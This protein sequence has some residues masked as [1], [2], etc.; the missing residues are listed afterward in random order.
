MKK[1]DILNIPWFMI[2]IDDRRFNRTCTI[3]DTMSLKRPTKFSGFTFS[4]M[5][6][7]AKIMVA[8]LAIVKMA[9]ALDYDAVFVFE[10]DAYPIDGIKEKLREIS[11]VP[12]DCKVLNLGWIKNLNPRS[13]EMFVK[14]TGQHLFG[15]HAY[16]VF[17]DGY[18]AFEKYF[19]STNKNADW[20][21]WHPIPGVY[22]YKDNL[23]VQYNAEES[24]S[25]HYGYIYDDGLGHDDPPHGYSRVENVLKK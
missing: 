18:E 3:F 13:S 21:F 6:T 16:I 22:C 23:F 11:E 24:N 7:P 14:P 15:E 19:S 5:S 9:K 20:I 1:I 2:T 4:N 8:N 25:M 10:D 12:D 17:K